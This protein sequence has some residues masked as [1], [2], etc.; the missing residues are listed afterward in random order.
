MLHPTFIG[1]I[2][3][4]LL[5]LVASRISAKASDRGAKITLLVVLFFFACIVSI[6]IVD[7]LR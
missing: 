5:V 1:T 2:F 3:I 4:V 6:I 7:Q